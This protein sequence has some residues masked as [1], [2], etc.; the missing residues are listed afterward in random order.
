M[1]WGERGRMGTERDRVST[2]AFTKKKKKKKIFKLNWSKV[3]LNLLTS[4]NNKSGIQ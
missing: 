4:I 1:G 3:N 2:A